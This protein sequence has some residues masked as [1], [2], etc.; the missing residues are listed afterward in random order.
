MTDARG[1]RKDGLICCKLLDLLM[2]YKRT[3]E[4]VDRCE[5]W[6][7]EGK[8][9]GYST[10]SDETSLKYWQKR[11]AKVKLPHGWKTWMELE[12]YARSRK[13]YR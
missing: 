5:E 10:K 9:K 7:R 2:K 4:N 1:I 13:Q 11:L 6:I 8:A 12:T 3:L